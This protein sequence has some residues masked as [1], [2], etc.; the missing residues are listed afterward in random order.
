MTNRLAQAQSLYLR[1]H[2][3]NPIEWWTWCDEALETAKREDKPIFLSIGYSSCHWCTVMEG[4][5]FSDA[6]IADYMNAN[7]LPIKVDREE[8]PDLDSIYMQALQMMVGQ[9]G[10]PLNIFLAPDDLVPFYGGT[11]FPIDPRYGRPGFLQVLQ[12]IR[13]YYDSEKGKLDGIKA[14]ILKNLQSSAM[15]QPTALSGDLLK[16]GLESSTGV[17]SSKAPGPSFPMIPYSQAA[18][19]MVRFGWVSRYDAREFTTQRG[20]DLAL[21]GIFDQVG[22]GFHRYTVDPTWTVPHFEKMLY[23]NGQIVEYLANLWAMGVEE[24]AFERSISLTV[25]WLKREMTAPQGYFYAAQDADSFTTPDET[26]PEEGAFYVW[27]FDELQTILSAEELTEL[28]EQFTLTKPGNFEGLNVLQRRH[29]GEL[30]ERVEG[31]IA[32]LFLT[33]YGVSAEDLTTFPPARNNHEAKTTD[34]SGRIPAVTDTKMI[35][36]W[37]S[38]MIS[39]LAHAY[40]VFRELEY[41]ELASQAAKFILQNQWIEGRL[42]RVNYEGTVEVLAQS[43]DYALFIKA[44]LDLHQVTRSIQP[45][46]PE[47]Q[48]HWLDHAIRVQEEFDEF[49]WSVELGGYYNTAKDASQDLLV[50]ERSYVDNA[51]P[52]A[53]GVAIV[54]LVQFA[55]L[56]EDLDYLDKAEQTLQAFGSVMQEAPTACPSLFVALDWFRNCTLVRSSADQIAILETQYLPTAVFVREPNLPEGVVGL[57]CQALSCKEPARS[58]DQLRSQL[59]QSL[60]RQR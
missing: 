6:T 33:R 57:V 48:T 34:W 40:A 58:I 22:G 47:N 12:S 3:E 60:I 17:L 2:A 53:N 54:N 24:P 20:L 11:Y 23:D 9:G 32:K 55:L 52:A 21:G 1:K 30:S 45:N 13:R 29:S 36:A 37:N 7:F 46:A 19:R 41:L 14:E 44:L 50:R 39:G 28:C 8:R 15:L 35:V 16:E 18:L 26:E 27:S 42:H 38:L 43:E 56:T 4:E 5:A 51:T 59:Q 10:W 25:Q 49:L 31:A